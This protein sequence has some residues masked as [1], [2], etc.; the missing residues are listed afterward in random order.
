MEIASRLSQVLQGQVRREIVKLRIV[1]RSSHSLLFNV[2]CHRPVYVRW[3]ASVACGR[4][5]KRQAPES[6]LGDVYSDDN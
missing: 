5:E 6:L 3:F 2:V 1:S 4:V